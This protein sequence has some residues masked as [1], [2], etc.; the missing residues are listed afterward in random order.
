MKR[1]RH[2]SSLCPKCKRGYPG[3]LG[4][5]KIGNAILY[6]EHC[7]LEYIEIVPKNQKKRK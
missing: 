7:K 5:T 4:N 3:L 6:C 2:N 1:P